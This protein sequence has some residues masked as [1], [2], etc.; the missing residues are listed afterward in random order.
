APLS[1]QQPTASHAPAKPTLTSADYAKWETLGA[2]ALSPDGKWLAYDFRRANGTTELHYRPV[3]S[4]KDQSALSAS[5]PQFS[6]NSRWLLYTVTP[7]TAGGRGGRGGR[8]G[9]GGGRGGGGAP[10]ENGAAPNRNKVAIVD[11][12]T[13]VVTT[14]DD[15]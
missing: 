3:D 9:G 7:D 8:A 14:L 13:G 4:D 15:V 5:K 1:A 2:G 12:K 11:L 10:A 6:D